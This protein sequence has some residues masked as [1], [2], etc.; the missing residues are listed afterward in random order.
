MITVGM[1]YEII[2]GKQQEFE[3]VFAKVL[4]VMQD[5]DGHRESNLYRHVTRP[6]S[7]LIVSEWTDRSAFEDFTR[8][9]RFRNVVDWGKKQILASRPHHEIYEH[10]DPS[11]P[12]GP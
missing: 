10:S 4:Q 6:N 5:M 9:D 1:N 3:A 7:Y 2:E 11:S 12:S 8:S